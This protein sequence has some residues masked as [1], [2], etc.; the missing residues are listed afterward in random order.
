MTDWRKKW[1]IGKYTSEYL[2]NKKIWGEGGG[3]GGGG[4]KKKEF[5]IIA[6]FCS[7]IWE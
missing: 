3:G 7:N 1:G 4:G 2:K 6:F 5:Y